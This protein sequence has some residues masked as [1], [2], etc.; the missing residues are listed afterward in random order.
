MT[1]HTNQLHPPHKPEHSF[2][3]N[4]FQLEIVIGTAQIP[5]HQQQQ[6][7]TKKAANFAQ[8]IKK[9][10]TKAKKKWELFFIT[11]IYNFYSVQFITAWCSLA[12]N[13]PDSEFFKTH[14]FQSPYLSYCS[15]DSGTNEFISTS[16]ICPLSHSLTHSLSFISYNNM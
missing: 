5:V 14:F 10:K 2:S 15:P 4:N 11:N 9:G 16:I 6:Q 12:S 1:Y 8:I 3:V 7:H 13:H